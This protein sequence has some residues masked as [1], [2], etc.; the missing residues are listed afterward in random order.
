MCFIIIISKINARTKLITPANSVYRV[1]TY[2]LNISR[3]NDEG[4]DVHRISP[5]LL[6]FIKVIET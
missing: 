4:E 1:V 6:K 5:F 2:I 3:F